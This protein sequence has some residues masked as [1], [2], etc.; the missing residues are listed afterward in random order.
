MSERFAKIKLYYDLGFWGEKAVRKAVVK[1][2][3]TE[4]ECALILGE[5]EPE[6]GD[7]NEPVQTET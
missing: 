2:W 1:G 6:G 4:S 7:Q 3:I 5:N